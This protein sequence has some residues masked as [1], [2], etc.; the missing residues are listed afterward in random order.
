MT[1]PFSMSDAD[2][3]TTTQPRIPVSRLVDKSMRALVLRLAY[4]L[5]SAGFAVGFSFARF[6]LLSGCFSLVVM[7]TLLAMASF[8]QKLFDNFSFKLWVKY[9]A[10]IVI[11]LLIPV[12]EFGIGDA[13][14]GPEIQSFPKSQL[15][16]PC[17]F[18]QNGSLTYCS[19]ASF[20]TQLAIPDTNL[21][22]AAGSLQRLMN[23]VQQVSTSLKNSKCLDFLT[24]LTCA[25]L[26]RTCSYD[27][28]PTQVC[29]QVYVK[30]F[31][32]QSSTCQSILTGSLD[33]LIQAQVVAEGDE[34]FRDAIL[35]LVASLK[36][37]FT[38]DS[39]YTNSQ[40]CSNSYQRYDLNFSS[41][42]TDGSC[43]SLN[44]TIEQVSGS[45]EV[46]NIHQYQ[47]RVQFASSSRVSLIA[48]ICFLLWATVEIF[49]RKKPTLLVLSSSR[50]SVQLAN[51]PITEKLF[52]IFI[53]CV[54]IP[55]LVLLTLCSFKSFQSM[56]SLSGY[57]IFFGN[58][59]IIEFSIQ[60]FTLVIFRRVTIPSTKI[61]QDEKDDPVAAAKQ[62][63]DMWYAR[64]LG[65]GG[66]F[67][68]LSKIISE[69]F[70]VALQIVL[71]DESSRKTDY[72]YASVFSITIGCHCIVMPLL[73]FHF[74]R[75]FMRQRQ[76]IFTICLKIVYICFLSSRILDSKASEL[77]FGSKDVP[78]QTL[79]GVLWTSRALV[80]VSRTFLND[81]LAQYNSF[82]QEE[83][84]IQF[85]QQLHQQ[86]SF[87]SLR[88]KLV[89]C[90]LFLLSWTTGLFLIIGTNVRI[91]FQNPVCF[92]SFD[93]TL[94]NSCQPRVLF[95]KG[96]FGETGCQFDSCIYVIAESSGIRE[97]SAQIG[98]I[99]NVKKLDLRN[100]NIRHF[101]SGIVHLT[102]LQDLS[103]SGNPVESNL[104]WS[105]MNAT[106]IPAFI[107]LISS[108]KK[109]DLSS[110][111][112][113]NVESL[114]DQK[115][116]IL[117]NLNLSHN[118]LT[119]F[120]FSN[121]QD[122]KSLKTLNVAHNRFSSV[123]VGFLRRSFLANVIDLDVSF[124]NLSD[125]SF[126][127]HVAF[128]M[129]KLPTHANIS[130][131]PNVTDLNFTS[132]SF[133]VFTIPQEFPPVFP[134][135][136]KAVL[137]NQGMISFGAISYQLTSLDV[138]NNSNL[139]TIDS[140]FCLMVKLETWIMTNLP[141]FSIFADDFRGNGVPDCQLNSLIYLNY[142]SSSHSRAFYYGKS[143]IFPS[144]EILDISGMKTVF[145]WNDQ[146]QFAAWN[147]NLVRLKELHMRNVIFD[148][149]FHSVM[150]NS[151]SSRLRVDLMSTLTLIDFKGCRTSNISDLSEIVNS[152]FVNLW[153]STQLQMGITYFQNFS[154]TCKNWT[155]LTITCTRIL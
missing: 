54:P 131:F 39:V 68:H 10:V 71:L 86:F 59:W 82:L 57:F 36:T 37:N 31:F 18:V 64:T 69:V 95:P 77:F 2:T 83:R 146:N 38:D 52:L 114:A 19:E 120:P 85:K 44:A 118:L 45:I 124:N 41:A 70:Q 107:L 117:E 73:L 72:V 99:R 154:F 56:A 33:T 78:F 138:S 74:Y 34:L 6:T 137:Q 98:L 141:K 7:I 140:S 5:L 47:Q 149:S 1:T 60:C 142:S 46:Q 40:S 29:K 14:S 13:P 102:K 128:W 80:G 28:Q 97:L 23:Q 50:V 134:N 123:P 15:F 81:I 121:S 144:L 148:S 65:T 51:M 90:L 84:H 92:E 122:I 155:D 67:E 115:F 55:M 130:P 135:V 61:S 11:T 48:C 132:P 108:L 136:T 35:I 153:S 113:L 3:D 27:C 88:K 110:N 4:A 22:S 25:Y 53:C 112:L 8:Y 26:F 49:L 93:E 126:F 66:R 103:V 89:T 94:W 152:S 104:T 87:L 63:F 96:V 9:F 101:P 16:Q 17:E 106:H 21:S 127:I 150:F 24:N 62:K 75:P 125:L 111:S 76:Q 143:L 58:L 139:V 105:G 30:Q 147:K 79:F 32:N 109:L 100:N 12:S 151:S 116:P 91:S 20:F 133:T 129:N 42:Q 119:D 145:P 43:D